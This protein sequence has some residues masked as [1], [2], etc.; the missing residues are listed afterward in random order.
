MPASV[1]EPIA[2]V[3]KNSFHGP[4]NKKSGGLDNQLDSRLLKAQLKP[5]QFD[6]PVVQSPSLTIKQKSKVIVIHFCN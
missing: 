6:D 1:Y 4:G 5:V 2:S 3:L